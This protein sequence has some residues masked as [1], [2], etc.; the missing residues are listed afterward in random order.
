M[1]GSPVNTWRLAFLIAV[2]CLVVSSVQAEPPK[3][4]LLVGQGPDGHPV[5]THEYMAGLKVLEKCLKGVPGLEITTVKADDPW[6]EGPDLLPR[7]D[8]VVL[9]VS[10]GA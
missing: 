1:E 2:G 4:L 6:K 9:F 10:E 5:S 3:K 7:A 8:A